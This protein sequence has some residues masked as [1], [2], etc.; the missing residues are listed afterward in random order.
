MDFNNYDQIET[1]K[2]IISQLNSAKV[3]GY[4]DE[5]VTN[6]GNYIVKGVHYENKG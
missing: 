1:L 5:K 4:S 2:D 6:K 3:Q